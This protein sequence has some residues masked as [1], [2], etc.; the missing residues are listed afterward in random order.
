MPARSCI[1]FS[2]LDWC[3]RELPEPTYAAPAMAIEIILAGDD[4]VDAEAILGID[5]ACFAQ[6]TVNIAE[7]LGRPWSRVWLA[8]PAGEDGA[9]RAFLLAWLV[10]DE[11]HVLSV[12]TLPAFRHQG[13]ATALLERTLQ[14][15]RGHHVRVVL[16]EVRR[17][18]LE[19]IRLYRQFGFSAVALRQSYY[20]DNLEDAVEMSLVLDPT[21]GAIVPG[22]D[23]VVL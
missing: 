10:A 16:L 8:R 6:G 13:L 11:L 5:R 23:E 1:S 7:E 17:S 15:A 22:H 4:G 2:N 19:A 21:T 12:A 18:N 20:V 3:E 9:P 14:F